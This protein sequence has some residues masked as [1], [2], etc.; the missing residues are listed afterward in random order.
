MVQYVFGTGQIFSTPVGGGV[1]L[2]LGA[3]QDVSIDFNGEIKTLHGQ[4]QFPLDTARGKTK[5]E[6]KIGS[7][8]IDVNAFNTIYFGQSVATGQKVQVQN[9]AGTVPATP[10]PY[11]VT[12]A[13]GANF[14]LDLGVT[15]AA[16]VPLKQVA[17]TPG[18]GEYTVSS[19]GVYTF[20]AAQE[21]DAM[22]FSYLY[23]D[24][25]NG[26]TLAIANPL[27][28]ITP[29]F[30]LILVNNYNSKYFTMGLYSV[31]AEKLSLPLKLD[32]YLIPEITFQAN[33]NDANNVGFI[34][35]TS[36]AGGGA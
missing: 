4:F 33:A 2:R 31:T 35:T 5:I 23:N 11:T 14:Y 3:L 21:G 13:N 32:D 18:S 34:S 16:G 24:A 12:V 15:T 9:E 1:P 20:N 28:G 29:K 27:M 22:L 6:G 7:A 36:V 25:A 19:L 8:N 30:Q 26:G 17:S 10:G